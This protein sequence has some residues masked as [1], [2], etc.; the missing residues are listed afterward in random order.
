L[1]VHETKAFHLTDLTLVDHIPVSAP[2]RTLV[3]LGAVCGP[4]TVELAVERAL[5]LR[6]TSFDEL[7]RLLNRLG[8]SG[9]RGVGTLRRVLSARGPTLGRAESDM[10]TRLLQVLRAHGLPD[11]ELQHEIR[12]EGRLVARVDAAYPRWRIALEYDSDEFHSGT[13]RRRRDSRR[14]NRLFAIGWTTVTV[15]KEDIADRGRELLRAIRGVAKD[16]GV[17]SP[18]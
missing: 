1:I 13:E 3:D 11:P 6:L 17:N 7:D 9:R 12:V 8:R 18:R 2:A 15:T 5:R 14:R 4:R 10:E 16:S